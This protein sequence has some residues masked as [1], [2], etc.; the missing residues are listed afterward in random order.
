MSRLAI[1]RG[2]LFTFALLSIGCQSETKRPNVILIVTDD[3]GWVD[4]GS[5][6]SSDLSTP[7]LDSLA[8]RGLRFTDFYTAAASCSPSRAAFM[9]GMYP[10]RVGIPGVLMPQSRRGLH[11]SALWQRCS[12]N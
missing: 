11:P 9:T 10:Q 7:H 3:Q 4:L 5:Y 12:R 2:I 1:V 8:A 6:G